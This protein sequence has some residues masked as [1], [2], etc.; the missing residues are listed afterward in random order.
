M[1]I[2]GAIG[3]I[4]GGLLDNLFGSSQADKQAELQKDFAQKGI[5]WRVK[6][7]KLAG[8]HP[9]Y[10]LGAQT[11]SYSPITVGSDFAGM[12]QNLGGA[13][14]AARS[15]PERDKAVLKTMSDLQIDHMRLQ[16]DLLRTQIAGSAVAVT[17]QAGRQAPGPVIG[18]D[19]F[20][21]PGQPDSGNVETV[22]LQV[23]ASRPGQ[24]HMEA[25]PVTDT[26]HT[27][28]PAGFAPVMSND[29][30]QRLEEDFPGMIQ[31]NVRNRI[32]PAFSDD[33]WNPPYR[34]PA[35][36]VWQF[37]YLTGEYW[38]DDATGTPENS[39]GMQ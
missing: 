28:T 1:S 16:N 17:R 36:K 6:D 11:Q 31:W 20:L 12:G 8:I 24:P 32:M 15:A 4:A 30:R 39:L 29:A 5:R 38:L 35:G 23:D 22:P 9:L 25:G 33:R 27:R 2:L 7:A 14:D 10:A 37:N 13:I 34:A 3:G 26:G 18:A 19:P 21:V